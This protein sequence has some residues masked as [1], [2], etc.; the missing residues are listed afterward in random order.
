MLQKQPNGRDARDVYDIV[1]GWVWNFHAL[2]KRAT[3][4][5]SPRVTNQ[6][7]STSIFFIPEDNLL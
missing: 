5:K 6:K 1:W 2:S 3:L 4:L 7:G